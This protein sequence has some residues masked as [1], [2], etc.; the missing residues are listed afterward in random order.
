L[1]G[2]GSEEDET[3]ALDVDVETSD[4]MPTLFGKRTEIKDSH[5][6]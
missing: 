5:D 6:R 4:V 1:V 3:D 2:C